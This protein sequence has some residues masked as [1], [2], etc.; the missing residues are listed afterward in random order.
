MRVWIADIISAIDRFNKEGK[1]P[2]G[3]LVPLQGHSPLMLE[4]RSGEPPDTSGRFPEYPRL[5]VP[6]FEADRNKEDQAEVLKGYFDTDRD[7]LY[8]MTKAYI[9]RG[10]HRVYQFDVKSGTVQ[11]VR[12]LVWARQDPSYTGRSAHE[13]LVADE[14]RGVIAKDGFAFVSDGDFAGGMRPKVLLAGGKLPARSPS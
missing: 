7:C 13:W 4:L 2:Y 5:E 8:P 9:K 1:N 3:E 12:L 6:F 14:K 10:W 11:D